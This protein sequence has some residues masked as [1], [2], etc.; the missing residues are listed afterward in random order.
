MILYNGKTFNNED[1]HI[2]KLEKEYCIYE[3]IRIFKG[4]PIFLND[5]INRLKNSLNKANINFDVDNSNLRSKL[6][7]LVQKDNIIDGNFKYLLHITNI[8]SIDE[9][10]FQI[11]HN[12]P[13]E[14]NY[15]SGVNTVTYHA[16]RQNPE[17]KYINNTLRE[18]TN[19]LI[20]DL[21]IFEVI[22]F[23]DS[24]IITEGSRSNIFFIKDD[25]VYTAPLT[26]VLPGTNRKRVIE[27]CKKLNI[28]LIEKPIYLKDVDKYD[29]SFITGTS[30]LVLPIKKIDK[31]AMNVKNKL[32]QQIMKEYLRI[33][34][35]L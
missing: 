8:N 29:S 24:N 13:S 12:Y 2:K 30:P 17:I 19:K 6:D 4:K 1:I 25:I 35:N 10:L 32:T 18:D 9:I 3:V 20:K 31:I 26:Y 28:K 34:H 23:D 22:L 27:I 14:E 33:V 15:K 16:V 21:N 7:L 5:N 11:P